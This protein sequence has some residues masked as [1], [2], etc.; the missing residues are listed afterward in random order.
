ME[1]VGLVISSLNAKQRKIYEAVCGNPTPNNIAWDDLVSLFKGLGA[2]VVMGS[3]SST[4]VSLNG[5]K[6][7]FHRPHPQKEAGRG[8]VR[9][10][11]RFIDT[12]LENE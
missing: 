11:R 1:G 5:V 8:L 4:T 3:G 7:S 9:Q 6:A 10:V 12:A 2:S